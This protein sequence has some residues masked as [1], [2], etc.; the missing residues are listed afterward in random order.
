MAE[1]EQKQKGAR[2][3]RGAPENRVPSKEGQVIFFVIH[4]PY[5]LVFFLGS[6]NNII[7]TKMSTKLITPPPL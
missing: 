1:E 3:A 6:H 4:M 5:V 2:A 7:I